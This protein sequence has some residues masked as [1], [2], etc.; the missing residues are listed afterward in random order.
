MG[1]SRHITRDIKESYKTKKRILED[2]ELIASL[3]R[4]SIILVE[5]LENGKKILF[6]GNGGSAADAQH[7]SAE[8]VGR[9]E[10]ERTLGWNYRNLG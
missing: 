6:A 5:A 9:F 3:E 8:L 2:V 7:L 10:I 1:I 4:I